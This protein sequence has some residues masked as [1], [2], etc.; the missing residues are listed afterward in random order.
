MSSWTGVCLGERICLNKPFSQTSLFHYMINSQHIFPPMPV[1]AFVP[2]NNHSNSCTCSSK[3][4][5]RPFNC[6]CVWTNEV[7]FHFKMSQLLFHLFYICRDQ[8]P[9]V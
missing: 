1:N 6:G 2:N 9:S 4:L 8:F 7:R 5:Y 3:D